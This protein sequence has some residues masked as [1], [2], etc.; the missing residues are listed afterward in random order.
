MQIT[1][2]FELVYYTRLNEIPDVL[3]FYIEVSFRCTLKTFHSF[4]KIRIYGAS[5]YYYKKKLEKRKMGVS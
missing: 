4:F 5:L 1:L 2:T 3:M